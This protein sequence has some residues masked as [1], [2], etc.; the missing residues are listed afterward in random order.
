MKKIGLVLMLAGGVCVANAAGTENNRTITSTGHGEVE[1]PQKVALI[2]LT[3]NEVAKKPQDAQ[4]QAR[5]KFEQVLSAIKQIQTQAIYSSM[6]SVT[7]NWSY[8]DNQS[9]ITGYTANYSIQVK[10][11]IMNSGAVID[12]AVANGASIVGNP[13]LFATDKDRLDAQLL[14][15]KLATT[16]ARAKTE[17][18]LAALGLKSKTTRQITIQNE[19][20]PRPPLMMPRMAAMKSSADSSSIPA[21]EVIAGMDTVSADVTIV[22]EY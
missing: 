19:N 7:P 2:S 12:K 16:D 5:Q 15:I 13:Q 9:K 14:A 8:A 21:T 11:G 17:A 4:E 22:S 18:S 20:Q 3:V 10:T 6:V 1:I